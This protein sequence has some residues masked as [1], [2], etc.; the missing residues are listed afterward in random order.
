MF[1]DSAVMQALF[2]HTALT[3]DSVFDG[4]ADYAEKHFDAGVLDAL[5]DRP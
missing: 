5:L 2:G 3:L 1:K 4:L